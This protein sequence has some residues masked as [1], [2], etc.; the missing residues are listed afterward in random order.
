[1]VGQKTLLV[2]EAPPGWKVYKETDRGLEW[3]ADADKYGKFLD[4]K[5]KGPVG[6]L[7]PWKEWHGGGC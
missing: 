3:I 6:R 1:M 4:D 5:H 2:M 7:I